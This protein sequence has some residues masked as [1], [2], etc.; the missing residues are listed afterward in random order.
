MV[1]LSLNMAN[2]VTDHNRMRTAVRDLVAAVIDRMP[3][4]KARVNAQGFKPMP[5]YERGVVVVSGARGLK[6]LPSRE[7]VPTDV[8]T[9]FPQPRVRDEHGRDVL[10]DDATGQ[11][12]RVIVWNNRPEA[13]LSEATRERLQRLGGVLVH[14]VPAE[15]LSWATANETGGVRVVGDLHGGLRACSTAGP[16]PSPSYDPTTRRGSLSCAGAG[17][18][19]PARLRGRVHD[20]GR[21]DTECIISL[22]LHHILTNA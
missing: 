22:K 18:D 21:R 2:L 14:A 10:L 16:P 3:R 4:T 19:A 15:Q 20:A 7:N 5:K 13:F 1:A 8:G 9:L 6:S 17:D 12:W 11:G